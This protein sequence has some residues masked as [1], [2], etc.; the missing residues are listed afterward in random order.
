[1][2][3]LTLAQRT[4]VEHV[5]GPLLILAG[6]GS[7]KT[8]VVTHRIA[9]LV[10]SGIPPR[11]ILAITFTN[12]A[13][14]EM[15]DRIER[16]LPGTFLWATTFHKFCARM[17]RQYGEAVGIQTNFSILDVSDQRRA[18]KEVM[19][20]LQIDPIHY[21]PD[22][23]AWRISSAKND[24]LTAE[25]FRDHN[26]KRT[27]SH[28]D[29][30]V[31]QVYPAYQKWLLEA[32]GVD[33]DDLLLHTAVMLHENPELRA[34]LDQRFRYILVDE[35]QDT[36][37]AQY[38]IVASMSKDYPNLC[39]TG[40]PDQSIYGWRGAQIENILRFERDYRGAKV[41]RLEENFRSTAAILRSAD[42]LIANNVKRKAKKLIAAKGD[43][44]SVK[45][46]C[47]ADALAEADGVAKQIE[48]LVATGE[49]TYGDMA[50]I[51]RVNA[52]SRQLEQSFSRHRVPF[53]LASGYAF[54]DR[55][56]IKDVLAYL[57]LIHN[58]ADRAA[59]LRAVNTPL[60]GLGETSQRK[61]L[62]W[63]D[64]QRLTPLEACLRAGEVPKLAAR[65]AKGFAQFGQMLQEF[66][67]SADGGVASLLEL[68][69][70][71]TGFRGGLLGSPSEK[72]RERLHN[73]E[74]LVT[75]AGQFDATSH[76]NATLEAFL[77]TTAL[78]NETD[79]LEEAAPRVTMMTLHAAKGLEFPV[80]F[81]VGVE[82]GLIPHERSKR[83]N[84][85]FSSHEIEEE[86]RLLFVG[87]TRAKERLFLTQCRFRALHGR[88]SPSIVS[89]FLHE[90]EHEKV[91]L[92]TIQFPTFHDFPPD[93]PSIDLSADVLEAGVS[94]I[95]AQMDALISG[96][97]TESTPVV[98]PRLMTAADLL[99]GAGG[100]VSL[101]QGFALGMQVRHPRYGTGTVV[102]LGGY[103]HR[104]TVTVRFQDDG[105][106]QN[107]VANKSPLQPIG[108]R[109]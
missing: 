78:V 82:D 80:V 61:L 15:Q 6:P 57:R 84:D 106:E 22:K 36:N 30:V 72:D 14:G 16:L 95:D 77:E 37:A 20:E 17:L 58:P 101:P 65:A 44:E 70:D 40:D 60:R 11:Q 27:G 45:L 98:V 23:V 108:N 73:I 5:D 88:S 85:D 39:V 83:E 107:F 91:M 26:A 54:Y 52:L 2:D 89:M 50:I 56:E 67:T 3:D 69:I 96:V 66:T 99:S 68:V 42:S 9:N 1:M 53:Q 49:Y 64:A 104:K 28:W 97:K 48:E 93:E 24:L 4:A 46:L 31:A 79:S 38:R 51:Y 109:T 19:H 47:F 41:V 18:I 12:K 92:D 35:Y 81:I 86:R 90:F 34:T 75:A 29:A 76:D 103:G 59:F 105:R 10:K 71:R 43:G 25:A 32:N 63:G 33:F 100:T 8:R 13:A 62:A 7:G 87:M 55:A 21:S 94:D 74:E 102:K